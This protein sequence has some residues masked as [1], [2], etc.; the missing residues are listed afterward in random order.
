MNEENELQA[1]TTSQTDEIQ[2]L[3]KELSTI[4]EDRRH[5]VELNKQIDDLKEENT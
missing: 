3:S 2:K 4:G 5:I 1:L